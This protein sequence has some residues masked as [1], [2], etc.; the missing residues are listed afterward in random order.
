MDSS[1]VCAEKAER[2]EGPC[3]GCELSIPPSLRRACLETRERGYRLGLRDG[4]QIAFDW[5]DIKGKWVTLGRRQGFDAASYGHPFPAG[6]DVR[7]DVIVW[8]ARDPDG[9]AQTDLLP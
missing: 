6:I 9:P 2:G 8:C 5:A 1:A 4:T 7:L 3:P